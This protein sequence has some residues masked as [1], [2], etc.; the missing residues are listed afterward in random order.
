MVAVPNKVYEGIRLLLPN[1]QPVFVGI[2]GLCANSEIGL[3]HP[4]ESQGM[5]H[6]ERHFSIFAK[7]AFV[8]TYVYYLANELPCLWIII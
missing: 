4:V 2:A 1:R 6:V 8:E 5:K 3:G 7:D